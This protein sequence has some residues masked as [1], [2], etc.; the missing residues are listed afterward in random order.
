MLSKFK[1]YPLLITLSG[2]VV[3]VLLVLPSYRIN[4]IDSHDWGGDFAMYIKQAQNIVDGKAQTDN[5]YIFNAENA[6]LGP[7]TYP[8]GFPL[9]LAP[10][11]AKNGTD[12]SGLIDLMA[13][14]A[15]LFSLV[16][17][18][19]LHQRVNMFFAAVVAIGIAYHTVF[20][21]FKREVMADIPFALFSLLAVYAIDQKKWWVAVLSVL[22]AILIKS[23]GLSLLFA[24][25]FIL[26]LELSKQQKQGLRV[27]IKQPLFWLIV[28]VAAGNFL[29]SN[30]LFKTAASGGYSTIWSTF[31]LTEVI[32]TNATYYW[33]F[34]RWFYFDA[35]SELSS[36]SI[37]I[38]LFLLL[39]VAGWLVSCFKKLG[40]MEIWSFT[41]IAM[42]FAYPYQHAGIRFVLP[43]IPIL[44]LYAAT[45][46]KTLNTRYGNGL[47]L[48]ALI[49]FFFTAERSYNLVNDWPK[50]V[51]GPRSENA[52]ALFEYIEK[53]TPEKA[54]FLFAKPRVLGL[55][56][57]RNAIGN[58]RFQSQKSIISQ[59]DSIP[60]NYLI[61]SDA[62]WNP[63]LD[64]LL[65]NQQNRTELVYD[66]AGFKMYEWR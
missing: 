18:V 47:A 56:A 29:F 14:L 50:N 35:I 6:V 37:A 3:C 54:T 23:A 59:L 10:T 33:E 27:M 34:F 30:V 42:L 12:I 60:I 36:G 24:A 40:M 41:Y 26:F 52:I 51:D 65:I 16:I 17:F 8:I 38:S 31:K 39:A 2:L 66:S 62:L 5:N 22:L 25:G 46:L 48:A 64:T 43:L 1:E 63:S 28:T 61:Q 53:S 19:V 4:N 58:G 20:L 13:V 49:P 7:K 9:L 21:F 11:I 32:S 45:L 15:I 55:Y 44:F 57:N